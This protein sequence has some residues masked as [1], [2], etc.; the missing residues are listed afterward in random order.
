[1]KIVLCGIGGFASE[2]VEYLRDDIVHGRLQG[3]E[4]FG[5]TCDFAKNPAN[6][7]YD[8][9]FLGT[10]ANYPI[11]ADTAFVVTSGTPR[12][13]AESI[14]ALKSRGARLLSVVHSSAYVSRT[15]RIGEGVVVCAH[16]TVNS[17]A[18]VG[19]GVALNVACSVG[20]DSRVGDYSVLCP[21][22]AVNGWAEVG[23]L[24][25]LGTRATVFPRIKLGE[26]CVVDTHS[27]VKQDVPDRKMVSF[28]GQYLVVDNRLDRDA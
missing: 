16:A 12:W 6:R 14:E 2:I 28:R 27:Y 19:D 15:A 13:R 22:A 20:H 25:F 1:M 5:V 24:C 9:P 21:Y 7:V 18:V 17:N 11:D 23:R 26:S 4:L 3:F 10:T 8:L